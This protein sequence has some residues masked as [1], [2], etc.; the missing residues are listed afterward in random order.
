MRFSTII[1]RNLLRRGV[2]TGLTVMGL[3]I[4]VSAVVS[5]LGISWGFE[6][7]FMAI[8]ESK[9][10]DLVVVKAGIGDRLTSNLDEALEA[11]IQQTPGVKEASGSLT[12]VLSFEQANLVSVLVN[13]WKAGSLLFRGIRVVEGREYKRN[14]SHVVMLGRVLALNLNKKSG[15]PLDLSG[16]PFTVIGIYESTTVFENGALIVPLSD[17]QK[18]MGREKAVSGVVVSTTAKDRRSVERVAK[19]IEGRFRGTAAEPA[20]DF[21]KG[22]Y[23]IR[24][25]KSMAWATSVIAMVLGSVGVLNTMLMTV[26]ERTREIGI[27]RALGWKRGRVLSLVLGESAALGVVGSFL[28][29]ALG[30]LSVK[31]LALAPMASIFITADLP[32]TILLVGLLL[33]LALS[34]AGGFY[35]ALRAAALEPSEAL[36][37]E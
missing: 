1:A 6:R 2:R 8:Y 5:L 37:H 23:Q 19:E 32:P 22:D 14:E 25:V 36:R 34:L 33:G 13:G 4:G 31:I 27:L 21:V 15:D 29:T 11:K 17:L 9:G 24:L 26:F 16:E 18:M 7:S 20:R 35:P 10:I 28:G 30:Y 3:A 12:D